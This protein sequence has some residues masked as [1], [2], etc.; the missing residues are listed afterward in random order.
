MKAGGYVSTIA[1]TS[2]AT[3]T[4][5][6]PDMTLDPETLQGLNIEEDQ[7]EDSGRRTGDL[8]VYTFYF[9]NI[10]WS[11]LFIFVACCVMFILGLSFPRECCSLLRMKYL[12]IADTD[13]RDMA[14]VVDSG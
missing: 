3:S 8:T 2:I 1:G 14:S 13:E 5:R 7:Q 6:A 11:L 12:A 4:A 9:Q 10:G